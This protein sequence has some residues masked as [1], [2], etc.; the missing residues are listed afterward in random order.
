MSISFNLP[1]LEDHLRAGYAD[2]DEA[3]KQALL[4][5]AYR[6]GKLS[7]GR[8]AQAIGQSVTQTHDW[9]AQHRVGP[10]Y[11]ADDLA[12]DQDTLRLLRESTDR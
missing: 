1:E 2:L 8:L 10:N 7:I 3:A 6:T 9:L 4:I 11:T 5:D 12:S